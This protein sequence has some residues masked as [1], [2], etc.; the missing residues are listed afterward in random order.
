MQDPG[1]TL[2]IKVVEESIALLERGETQNFDIGRTIRGELKL[3]GLL[4]YDFE[5]E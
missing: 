4:S 2:N 3:E 5:L 1:E